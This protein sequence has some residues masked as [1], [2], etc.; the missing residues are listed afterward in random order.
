ME[1]QR[2]RAM[3]RV[4]NIPNN[5]DLEEWECN[6]V[7]VAFLG[8]VI[9]SEGIWFYARRCAWRGVA[10]RKQVF[11]FA[12]AIDEF[13]VEFTCLERK[14]RGRWRRDDKAQVRRRVWQCQEKLA[15]E[16]WR[17]WR[18]LQ[19]HFDRLSCRAVGIAPQALSTEYPSAVVEDRGW[20][21]AFDLMFGQ[22]WEIE[23]S[24]RIAA[25]MRRWCT[26]CGRFR[27]MDGGGQAGHERPRRGVRAPIGSPWRWL[28]IAVEDLDLEERGGPP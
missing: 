24:M 13:S 1:R 2:R 22:C 9:S 26:V 7:P 3:A 23:A 25:R 5:Y 11:G 17:L 15:Q 8:N 12:A 14:V 19:R 20:D 27:P 10:L 18:L 16:G 6:E 28:N 21:W 4:W